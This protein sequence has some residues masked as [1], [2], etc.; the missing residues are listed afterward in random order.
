[1]EKSLSQTWDLDVFFPGGS[2]S[3]EFA[4]F[5]EALEAEIGSFEERL[6]A[7]GQ[8]GAGGVPPLKD[9]VGTL[10][11]LQNRMSEA[12]AFVSC[13]TAQDVKDEQAKLLEGRVRQLSSRLQAALTRF[14]AL[15]RQVPEETWHQV[16]ADPALAP[17]AF[18]LNEMRQRAAEKLP[19]EQEALATALAVDGYHAWSQL[20]HTVVGRITI[21]FET[22][23]K[24][25]QLSVGQAF[26]RMMEDPDRSV[27]QTLFARWE[28]AWAREAELCAAALNHLAGFRLALYRSRGWDSV[29]KEPLDRNRMSQATLEAMWDVVNRNKDH[30]VAYLQRKARI[31]G[32]ERLAWYDL[33]APIG[34]L[35]RRIPYDEAAEFIVENFRR[36]SP[37][38]ADF[39]ARAFRERWIEAEDRP[40]KRPGGFCTSFRVSRQSRI[41]MTYSGTPGGVS[42]LAHELG[43]AYHQHVMND[44]PPLVQNYAM[45]VAETASTFAEMVVVDAAIQAAASPEERL[46]LLEDKI[47]RSVAFFMDIHARFLFETRFYEARKKGLLTVADLNGLMLE[48]QKEA[49]RDALGEYHPHFWASKLHFY[50]TYWPFYNFPYTFGYLFSYGVY[51]QARAEGPSFADRYVALLRDTGR[52]TVEDLARKHL[53]VDLTQPDFWQSAADLVVEDIREFLRLTE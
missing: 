52:M 12:G 15:L 43:H 16:V 51:A 45:N 5:L 19:P 18:A 11:D 38:M 13:L 53:G 40:G 22:D 36:F 48:A 46:A 6:G 42:T 50:I 21:P 23:G 7:A 10:Q 39:A 33:S 31:L 37:D 44:L 28:E 25:V 34:K 20:Y 41:F 26:N 9:L 8:A 17:V 27:R 30:L 32:V 49:F 24:T 2:R 4:R 3:P 1:M 35:T 14:E 29:L 47:Q